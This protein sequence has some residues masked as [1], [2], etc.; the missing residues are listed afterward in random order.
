MLR[1]NLGCGRNPIQGWIN[2]DHVALP[3]VDVIADLNACTTP[4][5]PF[6]DSSVDE[7]LLSHLLEHIPDV[8]PLMRELHRI[9]KPGALM[10]IHIPHGASDDAWEDPTHVRPY[11]PGSFGYFSQPYYWRADYGYRGDW[12]PDRVVLRVGAQE[13]EGQTGEAL[14]KRSRTERN[15]VREMVVTMH[16]VKPIRQPLRE[17]QQQPTVSFVTV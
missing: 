4:P 6:A 7:F 2:V 3:G 14:W 8:L 17:L 11:F 10:T 5:L 9:A 15:L 12:Q 1:L 13:C 16:A